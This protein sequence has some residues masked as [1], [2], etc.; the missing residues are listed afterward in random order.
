[1]KLE[2]SRQ[3][4]EKVLNIKFH[5]NPSSE[6]GVPCGQT[7]MKLIVVFR[8]FA[9]APETYR[10]IFKFVEHVKDYVGMC[11]SVCMVLSRLVHLFRILLTVYNFIKFG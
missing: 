11:M 5:P 10:T 1:M 6:S 7:D 8:N 2:L 4:F 9:K 3:I